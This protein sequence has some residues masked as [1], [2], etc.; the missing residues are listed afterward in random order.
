MN[1]FSKFIAAATFA[2]ST[3][4]ST[5]SI[6]QTP[7][8]DFINRSLNMEFNTSVITAAQ[9][10]PANDVQMFMGLPATTLNIDIN[11]LF[12]SPDFQIELPGLENI[13]A[14]K[15]KVFENSLGGE[16]WIGDV[17]FLD[18]TG[19]FTE[20]QGRAYFVENEN[21]LTGTINTAGKVFQIY[22]DGN[23]GQLVISNDASDLDLDNDAVVPEIDEQVAASP[24]I[25]GRR[26]GPNAA[27]IETPYTLDV[28]WVTTPSARETGQ[29]ML[30]LIELATATGNDVLENSQI[31]ARLN[32]VAIHNAENFDESEHSLR[33]T[34]YNLYYA[35]DGELDEVFSIRNN[36]G[37]DLIATVSNAGGCGIGFLDST[38]ASA[39]S[40]TSV[41][42]MNSYT[43]IHEFGH[44][45]GAH[46][47]VETGA[48]NNN[49]DFGYGFYRDDLNPTWRTVMSY[50]CSGS[51]CPRVPYFSH[52]QLTYNGYALGNEESLDNSRVW[53]VRIAEVAS[54]NAATAQSCTEHS[55]SNTSHVNEARATTRVEGETCFGTICFGGTTYYEAIGSG[56][57]MG[58]SGFTSTTLAEQP[59]GYF[60]VGSCGTSTIMEAQ[61][62]PELQNFVPTLIEG[63]LRIEGEVF[64][65]NADVIASV[66]AR[67][68]GQTTWTSG[69]VDADT[70]AVDIQGNVSES[71]SVEFRTQDNKGDSFEF[72]T[73]FELDV[74]SGEAPVITVSE[75]TGIDNFIRI[76]GELSD[77]DSENHSL[78]YKL[79]G[80]PDPSEGFWSAVNQGGPYWQFDTTELTSGWI[81]VHI[82][83]RDEQGNQSE[84][85][86]TGA[87]IL[88]LEAPACEFY[89]VSPANTR[90][91]GELD[92]V[93]SFEDA[94]LSAVTIETRVNGGAWTVADE[95]SEGAGGF[96]PF[97]VRLAD[98]YPEGSTVNV[99]MR[100]TDSTNLQTLC[101]SQSI[102]ITDPGEALPPSCEITNVYQEEGLIRFAMTA[103]DPNGDAQQV[104]AK[105]PEMDDWLQTWPGSISLHSLPIPGFGEVTL[106][107][108]VVDSQQNEGLCETIYTVIDAH[109]APIVENTY[110]G[111]RVS[112]QS[113]IATVNAIDNDGDV[114]RV[115]FLD[116]NNNEFEATR[117][118]EDVFQLRWNADLGLLAN[119][120]YTY[121]VL[122]IDSNGYV[123]LREFFDF[124]VEQELPPTFGQLSY[125]AENDWITISGR[126]DDPNDDARYV[127]FKLD[128]QEWESQ[129]LTDPN[130]SRT[131]SD[132][133]LGNHV[134]ELYV[135]D[136]WE[137]R[138]ES[139]FINVV[140]QEN[141][142]PRITSATYEITNDGVVFNITAIDPEGD[143][144]S[145]VREYDGQG[146]GQINNGSNSWSI[147]WADPSLG[148]HTA[149]FTVYDAALNP[150]ETVTIEFTIDDSAPCFIDTNANH[151]SLGRAEIIKEGETCYGTYCFG[152][153]DTYF[154]IGSGENLGTSATATTSLIES[155]TGYFEL[156]PSACA[157]TVPPI[158]TIPTGLNYE[159]ALGS[160]VSAP[161]AQATDNVDGDISNQVEITGVVNPNQI[162]T[163]YLHYNVSD[164]SGN[165]AEEVTVTFEVVDQPIAQCFTDTNENH[166]AAGRAEILYGV[167]YYAVV[168]A[169]QTADYLGG[170]A[171]DAQKVVSLE[172]IAPGHWDMVTSCN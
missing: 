151:V 153:T 164:S 63:G 135:E 169:G 70:F 129:F 158:I 107:G 75:A 10:S 111:Y 127:W 19:F 6:G 108:R 85:V 7:M 110:A 98:I 105:T 68:S 101:G 93:G 39:I 128:E 5:A 87:Q 106:Q 160:S 138:S 53:R 120:D 100:A 95:F 31:P 84:V 26:D 145:L 121:S 57:A 67:I 33:D 163:Y 117:D 17:V 35:N 76:R 36:V 156:S 155:S 74:S 132:L 9:A 60:S 146:Q 112:A 86:S 170:T 61:F 71:T 162:G 30:A 165:E 8:D 102:T 45:L 59:A 44:N 49:Y 54:F 109:Q 89:Q 50:N 69:V 64:D 82:F 47:N 55:A 161:T 96:R 3:V 1:T 126:A 16:N 23:G 28:L 22:P 21:G 46:H 42:C 65:A 72:S 4:F 114:T 103:F 90:V 12:S 125:L 172:E 119:G 20:I 14:I 2:G 171:L 152:G 130:F 62:G 123:S 18:P 51:N 142:P 124:N 94:N 139:E 113:V 32:I 52:S 88:P 136:R 41:G 118:P 92:V 147:L 115:I 66:E 168:P 137:L 80:T 141:L 154:T 38:T 150:S 134:I 83:A 167:S 77:P 116:E 149:T 140:V 78:H 99:E 40:V 81:S 43:P 24:L 97:Q 27:T 15:D 58:T 144:V 166:V 37:A 91:L 148:D 79:G 122:A 143:S 25:A 104:F 133:S 11:A 34:L 13:F 56:D 48:I 157:D 159:V 73:T 131:F 29:D